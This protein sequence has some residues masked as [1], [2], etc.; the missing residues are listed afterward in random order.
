MLGVDVGGT[1]TDVIAVRDGRIEAAKVPTDPSSPSRAS[2]LA[3][4]RG[5][6]RRG[7][8]RSSTT[9]ARSGS[10]R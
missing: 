5:P 2:V 7:P 10:T 1:F 8:R 6:G 3:G 9:R 4:R